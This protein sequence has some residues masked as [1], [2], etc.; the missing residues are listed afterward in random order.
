MRGHHL[1]RFFDLDGEQQEI[2]YDYNIAPANI[3][4]FSLKDSLKFKDDLFGLRGQYLIFSSG[5]A[6]N[7]RS[8]EGLVLSWSY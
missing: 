2:H 6:I 7:L 1:K 8:H 3:N 5:N 4:S